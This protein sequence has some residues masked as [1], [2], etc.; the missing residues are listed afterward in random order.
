M[1]VVVLATPPFWLATAITLHCL[2][3]QPNTRVR[4]LLNS[5]AEP[6]WRQDERASTQRERAFAN[7]PYRAETRM[8]S[9]PLT[10]VGSAHL[11]EMR[12]LAVYQRLER[13]L[14]RLLR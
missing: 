1:A 7:G 9:R 13:R 10:I 12:P 2:V 4:R 3:I 8:R 5:D 11:G 14:M 6:W